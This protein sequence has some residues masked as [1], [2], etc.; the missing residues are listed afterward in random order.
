MDDLQEIINAPAQYLGKLVEIE[1]FLLS[2]GKWESPLYLAPHPYLKLPP[3]YALKIWEFSSN[4]SIH[5]TIISIPR[6]DYRN[7]DF[8]FRDKVKVKGFLVEAESQL[9]F[10]PIELILYRALY[11]CYVHS[12]RKNLEAYSA[13]NS[14]PITPLYA[15]RLGKDVCM[16]GLFIG[17]DKLRLFYMAEEL[18]F[19]VLRHKGNA[20][21]QNLELQKLSILLDAKPFQRQLAAAIDTAIGTEFMRLYQAIVVGDLVESPSPQFKSYLTNIKELLISISGAVYKLRL[22]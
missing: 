2:Y 16:T 13:Y 21:I 17:N 7:S 5:R 19:D 9:H 11:E 22:S 18:V 20:S 4:S 14:V 10:Y 15:P 3:K 12:E 6:L 8:H 1:G